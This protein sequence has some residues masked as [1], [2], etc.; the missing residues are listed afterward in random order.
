MFQVHENLLASQHEAFLSQQE[1]QN[2]LPEGVGSLGLAEQF[3]SLTNLHN[4]TLA[5]IM[6]RHAQVRTRLGA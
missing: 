5:R 4:E 3:S 2:G 1:H 6:E